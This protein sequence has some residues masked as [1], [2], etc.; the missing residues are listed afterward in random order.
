MNA[1]TW[2]DHSTQSIWSQPWGRA[3]EG[4]LKDVQL[5]L[6]PSQVTTWASWRTEHPK[7]LAMTNGAGAVSSDLRQGFRTDFVI[8]LVLG[9]QSKAFYFEDAA[10]AGAIND[11]LD[12]FPVVVW[13]ADDR[14][15]AYVRQ[16]DGRTLTFRAEGDNLFDEET[17]SRWDVA[18]GLA[19]DGPLRG[20]VLQAVPSSTAYDWAWRDFYPDSDFYVP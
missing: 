20:S 1:M 7:T 18:R 15:H 5:D 11:A 19:V 14:F 17:G 4:S 6:L 13:A 10:A 9:D 3:I 12:D 2:Y 8:G 16:I